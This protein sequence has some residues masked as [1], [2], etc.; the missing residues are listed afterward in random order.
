LILK[1]N[2]KETIF[3]FTIIT[4]LFAI[5]SF[6]E[7]VIDSIA[8]VVDDAI[9]L[10]SEISYGVST[11][12]LESGNR[13]PAEEQ[14]AELRN[15][16]FNAYITQKI[17]LARAVEETL[18]VEDRVVDREL[19]RKLEAL[20]AQI[21]SAEKLVE[22]FGKPMRQIK[23]EM[24]D[25]VRDGLMI[26]SLKQKHIIG[27]RLRRQEVIDFYRESADEFPVMPEQ[28]ELSHILLNV[29]PSEQSRRQALEKIENARNQLLKGADFDSLAIALSEGPSAEDGGKL[30]F[31]NRGD[32]VPAY[33][34]AAYALEPGA[35]S[36]IVES[37]YGYHIIC[38]IER[39]GE[40][41]STQHIL[42][43]LKPTTDD[44]KSVHKQA[45]E[46]RERI[47]KGD[48]FSEIAR[49]YSDDEES[50]VQGGVL[51]LIPVEN[52]PVEF[53]TVLTDLKEGE[54]SQ[55]LETMYGVHLIR[56]DKHESAHKINL[57]KDWQTVEMYALANKR[58]KVFQE[59]IVSLKKDHY[60]WPER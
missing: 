2:I 31:T 38:L 30:G 20:I 60:I 59:W 16:V 46:L 55:P 15:Q 19:E 25:G 47:V 8:A 24:R 13:Y 34:E 3:F 58:E 18:T 51:D 14:I 9:I 54:L 39:Q 33:E 1:S 43:Q 36:D 10:E 22:Y 49:Q 42:I 44:W 35:I 23:R 45:V 28:V 53:Q 52:L 17:L 29:K 41:I 37:Q 27:I 57:A 50:A 5:P 12:L 21:G 32:L 11:L 26:E 48:K 56:L 6:A 40:R 4:L 7:E